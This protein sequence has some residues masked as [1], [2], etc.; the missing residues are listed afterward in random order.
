MTLHDAPPVMSAH[1]I[2]RALQLPVSQVKRELVSMKNDSLVFVSMV[3]HTP[4][5]VPR[6]MRKLSGPYFGLT[7]RGVGEAI[8]E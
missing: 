8:V 7:L 2:A 4:K 1:Q 3:D 5:R 6:P